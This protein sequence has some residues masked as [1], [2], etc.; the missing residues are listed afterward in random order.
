MQ[1]F[2]L[3]FFH[4]RYKA[5]IV[6]TFQTPHKNL[7]DERKSPYNFRINIGYGTSAIVLLEKVIRGPKAIV[8]IV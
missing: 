2:F 4:I 5:K 1:I 7:P 6:I 8:Y 3:R